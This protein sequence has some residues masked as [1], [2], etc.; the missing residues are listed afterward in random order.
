MAGGKPSERRKVSNDETIPEPDLTPMM[1]LAFMLILALITLAAFLPLGLITVQ[2]PR[3][4]GAGGGQDKP[5]DEDEK[6]PLNLTIFITKDGFNIAAT[7]A[8]LDGSSEGREGQPL[9][10]KVQTGEKQAYNFQDLN[11]RLIEIKKNFKD[12]TS[13]IITADPDVIYEDVISTMDAARMSADGQ[14][15]FP[16]VAFSAGIVG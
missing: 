1:N 5:K 16:A 9:V 6:P 13:V 12:E 10:P 11:R 4:A 3:L 8:T 15:L 2:A 14:I 7:G